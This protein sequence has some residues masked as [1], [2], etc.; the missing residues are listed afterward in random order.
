MEYHASSYNITASRSHAWNSNGRRVGGVAE[1]YIP[2]FIWHSMRA[3]LLTQSYLR[4]RLK[5]DTV[6]TNTSSCRKRFTVCTVGKDGWQA[7]ILNAKPLATKI[8]TKA[9]HF[10]PRRNSSYLR[11][12]DLGGKLG[13]LLGL[14]NVPVTSVHVGVSEYSNFKGT[15]ILS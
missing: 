8:C 3:I 2:S 10:K 7:C 15:C 14:C 6:Q 4:L 13:P 1:H 5:E 11:L 9:A 12:A